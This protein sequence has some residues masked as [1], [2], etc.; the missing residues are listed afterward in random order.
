M[1]PSPDPHAEI[2][3]RRPGRPAPSAR[4]SIQ[5]APADFG[6]KGGLD[7]W[8]YTPGWTGW[9]ETSPYRLL[10]NDL[11][12][13]AA[14]RDDQ[15]DERVERLIEIGK[16]I[17]RWNDHHRT[18]SKAMGEFAKQELR[19]IGALDFLAYRI[20][21]EWTALN[22]VV[23]GT[24]DGGER[25]LSPDPALT[26]AKKRAGDA[27]VGFFNQAAS[28]VDGKGNKIAD[29]VRDVLCMATRKDAPDD[30]KPIDYWW[31]E[32]A[33]AS[34]AGVEIF[35]NQSKAHG[36]FTAGYVLA[37]HISIGSEVSPRSDLRYS[38]RSNTSLFPLFPRQP[39]PADVKQIG[40][41]DCYLQAALISIA[42]QDPGFFPSI[43]RD[44]GGTVTVQLHDITPGDPKTFTPRRITVRKSVV[45]DKKRNDEAFS[46]GALWAQML[47]KA[48]TA[49]GYMGGS[50]ETMP[51]EGGA[52]FGR[53]ESGTT[54]IAFE[55]ILGR[56]AEIAEIRPT[57]YEFYQAHRG[58]TWVGSGDFQ[59][60]V[61]R[62][63]IAE[64]ERRAKLEAGAEDPKIT[65]L[66]KLNSEWGE[67]QDPL[68]E[69]VLAL[70]DANVQVRFDEIE[71]LI[72]R[73]LSG[74]DMTDLADRAV[75]WVQDQKIYPGKRGSGVYTQAQEDL[76]SK[77]RT[78]LHAGKPVSV[79]T[80]R[81]IA[82]ATGS[83]GS[84]G[85]EHKAKG[86]AGPHGY[87]VLAASTTDQIPGVTSK[88]DPPLK[89][90]K[91]R[92]PWSSYGREYYFKHGGKELTAK[93]FTGNGEFWLA[94]SDLTKRFNQI[95][96]G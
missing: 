23:H 17:Q 65:E 53:I 15:T 18:E 73:V 26:K 81:S 2:E 29:G 63:I 57:D 20:G 34:L 31:V 19:K 9:G 69:A 28:I 22:T 39:I 6:P 12:R 14:L 50:P 94:L 27:K 13:Y 85:N 54:N 70:H 32:P 10:L 4:D 76:Y 16:D 11:E 1:R 60:A 25:D 41:G 44:N 8:K 52:S 93:E 3:I 95:S 37:A 77:I 36:S 48:Y 21:Q 61:G 55:H 58:K 84:S 43:M 78:A 82:S 66:L 42:H 80:S 46:G 74:G 90:V 47:Q 83:R 56:A 87:A 38:D 49:A 35:G 89:M 24:L 64:V 72:R 91:L 75:Q 45:T 62:P 59:N 5:R 51:V 71:A 40:L 30:G 79:G 92:N 86:L 96:I 88:P 68:E 7:V 33:D 67:R